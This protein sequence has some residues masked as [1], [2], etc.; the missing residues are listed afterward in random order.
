MEDNRLLK[1]V[2]T[3][4]LGILL[5]VFIGV[6]I[7][8]FY[9]GPKAPEFPTELNNYGKEMTVQQE[10]KQR[11]FDVKMEQHNKEMRPYNRNVSIITL[12]AAVGFLVLSIIFEKRIKVIADG[13]MLG[14]LFTLLYSIGRGFASEDNK[15]VF[16]V[17]TVGL[18]VALYLGYH[19]FVKDHI[20][21]PKTKK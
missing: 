9:P 5:A 17:I 8:T 20:P 1:L 7:S 18:L 6:G 3:F 11:E 2:Y 15:Y 12:V 21:E 10:A 4:F 13:V 16:M 19:R 14:G